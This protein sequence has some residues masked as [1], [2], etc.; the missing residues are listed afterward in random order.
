MAD[1]VPNLSFGADSDDDGVNWI[2][3][4]DLLP[5]G[6]PPLSEKV[7]HTLLST[8]HLSVSFLIFC[9][10]AMFPVVW[11]VGCNWRTTVPGGGTRSNSCFLACVPK[12][13]T[14]QNAD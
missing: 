4:D 7:M 13:V 14:I 6:D 8:A 3:R 9:S 12:R 1:R 11:P 2:E 5:T 10:I